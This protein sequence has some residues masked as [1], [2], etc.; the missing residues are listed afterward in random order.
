MTSPVQKPRKVPLKLVLILPFMLQISAA[1]GLTGWLSLRNGQNA[2]DSLAAQ[3][4]NEVIE[5]IDQHL[6]SYLDVPQRSTQT[7]AE[8][9]RLGL[10]NLDDPNQLARTFWQQIQLY[11]SISYL[12]FAK[13]RDGGFVDAGRQ[14][15]GRLVIEQTENYVAG[16]FYTYG[17]DNN[18][19]RTEVLSISPDY[20]PRVR[21]W[22]TIV[23]GASDSAW[24]AVYTVFPESILVITASTPVYNEVGEFLGVFGADLTL[25]QLSQF[26]QNL[27]VGQLGQAAILERSGKVVALSTPEDPF[28]L[29]KPGAEPERLNLSEVESPMLRA[30]AQHLTQ[31]FGKLEDIHSVEQID[32]RVNGDATLSGQSE[33]YYLQVAPYRDARGLDWLILVVVPESDFMAQIHANTQQTVVLSL[34]A[35]MVAIALG[36]YTSRWISQPMEELSEASEAIASGELEYTVR[37][38]NIRE[39]DALAQNFNYM[40]RTLKKLVVELEAVNMELED[41]VDQR[42]AELTKAME[43][44]KKTQLQLV[45]SEKMS[46][47][48]QLVA[49]IAHEINNPVNFIHGNLS[50]ASHYAKGLLDLLAI[51]EQS[52]PSTTSDIHQ[53]QQAIDLDFVRE[54]FPRLVNSMRLGA[55]RIREIVASLRNFSC[56]DEIDLQQADLHTVIEEAFIIVENRLKTSPQ[57]KSSVVKVIR[58]YGEIKPIECYPS[59]LNQVFLNLFTNAFDAIGERL[60]F[61]ANAYPPYIPE[62]RIKTW[63]EDQRWIRISIQDNGS[64]IPE[65]FQAKLFD[66]FF[67]TKPVGRGTGLG[68]FMCYRIVVDQ[69]GGELIFTSVPEVGTEF[70]IKLPA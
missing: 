57:D 38:Q 42:T 26:M 18:A 14:Q 19:N 70:I 59:H 52:Y 11:P 7:Q 12:Y 50:H 2:V 30:A 29:W 45:Q 40:T 41:R 69:Y 49:G 10:L 24:S 64:G 58:Q 25:S 16:N 68:L 63:M 54:D 27:R 4:E 47:L 56:L 55:I 44:L 15:S 39:I 31:S 37:P 33:R 1:V 23:K 3:L 65:K 62:I 35:L 36:V 51:Y 53:T 28:K 46:S 6:S 5:R 60:A 66:P 48:G 61:T 17:T 21:P 34:I 8:A 43:E 32:F 20:D 13:E 9:V 22:Y 67:T